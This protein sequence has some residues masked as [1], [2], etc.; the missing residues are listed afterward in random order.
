MSVTSYVFNVMIVCLIA[1]TCSARAEYAEGSLSYDWD[2]DTKQFKRISKEWKE[3]IILDPQ[4]G[5][6][7][8][9]YKDGYGTWNEVLFEPATKIAPS[10]FSQFRLINERQTV[11]YGY[12][13]SN[14]KTGKQKIYMVQARVSSV[15][16]NG[17]GGPTDWDKRAVP[18]LASSN[19]ILTWLHDRANAGEGLPPG[20]K[21][22]GFI[23][24]SGDLP[25]IGVVEIRGNARVAT[26]LGHFPDMATP[27]GRQANDLLEKDFVAVIAAFPRIAVDNPFNGTNT[28]EA[29]RSHITKE[30]LDLKLIDPTIAAQLDRLLEAASNAVRLDNNKAARAYLHDGFV[31][32]MRS[33][34]DINRGQLGEDGVEYEDAKRLAARVIAFNLKY[35]EKR[36]K[37]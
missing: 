36:L 4:S 20:G 9:S 37:N 26:W 21:L 29:L 30:V 33:F 2:A 16:P 34:P 25:G 13:L 19:L 7:F 27:V 5:N 35:I 3:G 15:V 31:L 28:L 32:L 22:S 6:Y 17:I 23:I 18:D 14:A 11:Q 10:L 12:Q 24:E 1:F 8:V